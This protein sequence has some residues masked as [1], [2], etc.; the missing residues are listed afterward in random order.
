MVVDP[1]LP[2]PKIKMGELS[3]VHG[4][5]CTAST[6]TMGHGGRLFFLAEAPT[7]SRGSRTLTSRKVGSE[8]KT[9]G[10]LPTPLPFVLSIK[11]GLRILMWSTEEIQDKQIF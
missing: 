5:V 10:A 9:A 1:L 3:H 11:S 2:L 8:E 4:S 6:G 7:T